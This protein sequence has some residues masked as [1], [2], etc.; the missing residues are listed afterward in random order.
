[1]SLPNFFV[2]G[3]A[4]SG[5]TALYDAIRQHPQ[6]FMSPVKEPHYFAFQGLPPV[7]KGPAGDYYRRTGVYTPRDYYMLFQDAT[8]HKAIGEASPSYLWSEYAAE[9][10]WQE[11]PGS[12]LVAV[13]RQPAER[14]YS[15]YM[16]FVQNDIEHAS[17]FSAALEQ[18]PHRREQ[19]LSNFFFYRF[20][21]YYHQ[22]LSRYLRLFPREQ[23]RIYFYEDW[24]ES[25]QKVL[26]DLFGFLEVEPGFMPELRKVNVT[27]LPRSR[28]FDRFVRRLSKHVPA[29]LG[30]F[31]TRVDSLFNQERPPRLDP[32]VRAELTAGYREDIL[33]L[34]DLTGRDL[35]HWL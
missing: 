17:S 27:L 10:I 14:A 15:H 22:Q 34:Q 31:L 13:L 1:M 25:P 19:G 12:K 26:Q 20:F 30:A 35:G 24:K 5:T 32:A 3:A 28:R 29:P 6:I 11:L 8:Q 4:K 18:E 9:H 2:I 16:Y 33:R 21:G 23:I 7:F